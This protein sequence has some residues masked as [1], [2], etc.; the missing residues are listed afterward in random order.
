MEIEKGESGK[1]VAPETNVLLFG[2]LYSV[3][4]RPLNSNKSNPINSN[5]VK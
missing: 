1:G 2:Y 3:V 5:G 4:R